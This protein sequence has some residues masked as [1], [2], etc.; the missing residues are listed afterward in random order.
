MDES[1]KFSFTASAPLSIKSKGYKVR[2][3]CNQD[4]PYS[5]EINRSC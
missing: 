5:P 4:L 1:D 2:L 3:I